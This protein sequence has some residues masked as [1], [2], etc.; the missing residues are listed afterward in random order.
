MAEPDGRR[1]DEVETLFA[2]V[3]QRY[4]DRLTDAQLEG[5]RKAIEGIV[6]QARALRAVRLRNIDEPWPPFVPFRGDP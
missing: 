1:D 6:A 2:L 5:V 4:G 3:R